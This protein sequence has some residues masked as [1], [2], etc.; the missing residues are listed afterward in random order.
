VL[1][2][3]SEIGQERSNDVYFYTDLHF[4]DPVIEELQRL[5]TGLH[6]DDFPR[7]DYWL[8]KGIPAR[9]ALRTRSSQHALPSNGRWLVKRGRVP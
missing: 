8:D 3:A 2:S 4:D 1:N 5:A 6:T 9:K 7:L